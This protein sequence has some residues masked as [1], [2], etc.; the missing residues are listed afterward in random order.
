MRKALAP[1][2][3]DDEKVTEELSEK[4]KSSVVALSKR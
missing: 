4:S 1:L 3:L 2:L